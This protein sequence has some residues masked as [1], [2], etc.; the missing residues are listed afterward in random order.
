M[1]SALLLFVDLGVCR[2]HIPM[3]MVVTVT[4]TNGLSLV[5]VGGL[6]HMVTDYGK[7]GTH[8]SCGQPCRRLVVNAL[9]HTRCLP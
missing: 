9:G 3:V 6:G 8:I 5:G 1:A 2:I 7:H 4:E